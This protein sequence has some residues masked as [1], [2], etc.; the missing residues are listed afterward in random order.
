MEK[1]SS[2]DLKKM[3]DGWLKK[4]GY[5][6]V[7]AKTGYLADKKIFSIEL[8]QT[9]HGEKCDEKNKLDISI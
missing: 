7:K 1:A 6:I 9:C 5:P 3:A 2:V 4:T 8:V